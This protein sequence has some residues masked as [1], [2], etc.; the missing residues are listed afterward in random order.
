M[1]SVAHRK[2]LC[3]LR[4]GAVLSLL[5]AP[6]AVAS[7][8]GAAPGCSSASK[9]VIIKGPLVQPVAEARWRTMRAEHRVS[10][11]APRGDGREQTTVRGLIAVERPDRFRLRALGPGG[12]TLFDILKVGGEVRIVQGMAARDTSLQQKVLLSIG[13][14]L[15]AAYDLE[16]RLP[17]RTKDVGLKEGEV[18][19]VEPERSIRLQHFKE[20]QGQSIPTHM[21]I[22]NNALDYRVSIDVE[23]ATLDDKLDP[24]LFRL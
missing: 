2:L 6:A 13:A 16:P 21:E 18:R 4:L 11:D 8:L 3:A 23:S 22:Q 20:V 9:P 1:T 15:A 12:V 5:G 17:S 7:L 19:V 14:D 24:N 10:I